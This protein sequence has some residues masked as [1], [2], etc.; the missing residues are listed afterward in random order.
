MQIITDG[1]QPNTANFVGGY[2]QGVV[3]Q[4][5]A[6]RFPTLEINNWFGLAGPA[7]MPAEVVS[8]LADM[9][10]AVVRDPQTAER[11]LQRGLLP[12]SESGPVFAERIRRDRERWRQVVAVN[13]IRGD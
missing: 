9:F 12:L 8:D 11:M 5:L 4:W 6:A 1:A 2:A 13:N 7:A 10:A 3:G